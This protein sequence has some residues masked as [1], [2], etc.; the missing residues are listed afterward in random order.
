MLAVFF[1]ASTVE[2][3]QV[4]H[5]GND[6]VKLMKEYEKAEAKDPNTNYME[7]RHYGGYILGVHD[8]TTILYGDMGGVPIQ[9]ILGIVSRYLKTHPDKW[10]GPASDLV[11]EA[12]K[13]AFPKKP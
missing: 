12:L 1:L 11:I 10:N 5:D 8:A 7:V 13:E 3:Q 6:L 4:F 9:Q 2:A